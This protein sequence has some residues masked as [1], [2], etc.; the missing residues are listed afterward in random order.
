MSLILKVKRQ[1]MVG[2]KAHCTS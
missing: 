1:S 2:V